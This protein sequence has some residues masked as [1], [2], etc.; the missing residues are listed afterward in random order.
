[1]VRKND[2]PDEIDARITFDNAGDS[3]S[4]E[5]RERL[6]SIY[7]I[8]A[9]YTEDNRLSGVMTFETGIEKLSSPLTGKITLDGKSRIKKVNLLIWNGIQDMTPLRDIKPII[10]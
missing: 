4:D 9:V 7:V 8:I 6:E 1:M 5:E 3:V 10:E 2:T